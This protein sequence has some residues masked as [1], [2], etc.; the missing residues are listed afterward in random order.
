MLL[1]PTTQTYGENLFRLRVIF[2]QWE[3]MNSVWSEKRFKIYSINI[4]EKMD[5]LKISF[6][7]SDKPGYF[8]VCKIVE[9]EL[10]SHT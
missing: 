5:N 2:K 3:L 6:K 1:I 10:I 9:G 8:N 7:I 4:N